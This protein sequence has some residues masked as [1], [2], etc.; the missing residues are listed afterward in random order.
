LFFH[1]QTTFLNYAG[2]APWCITVLNCG[3]QLETSIDFQYSLD[4]VMM[5]RSRDRRLGA[6]VLGASTDDISSQH[7]HIFA[8]STPHVFWNP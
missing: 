5:A 6:F 2:D 4:L 1:V 7:H 3:T 8:R